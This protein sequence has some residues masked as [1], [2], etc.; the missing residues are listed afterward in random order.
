MQQSNHMALHIAL[1]VAFI[2]VPAIS[3]PTT[4]SLESAET[5]DEPQDISTTAPPQSSAPKAKKPS[6]K[7]QSKSS[8][9]KYYKHLE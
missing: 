4:P 1:A 6:I 5:G 8:K 9:F 2:V 7:H 3:R